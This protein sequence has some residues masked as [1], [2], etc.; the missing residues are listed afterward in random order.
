MAL[1]K[2]NS[3]SY[4]SLDATKLTGNLPAISGANLTGI[5]AANHVQIFHSES[6]TA[7]TDVTLDSIFSST[8]DFYHIKALFV[9]AN[10]DVDFLFRARIGTG[11][12]TTYSGSEYQWVWRGR[13]VGNAGGGNNDN[14]GFSD[15]SW[16]LA[17]NVRSDFDSAYVAFT[18]D[19]FDPNTNITS[20]PH[21]NADVNWHN[22]S[23]QTFYR[24]YASGKLKT[25][26]DITGLTFYFSS[27]NISEAKIVCYGVKTT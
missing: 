19:W 22:A 4:S 14:S 20:R 3:N 15:T 18:M 17:D 16:K 21:Y 24:N 8:Y 26:N 9:P 6:Q 5:V 23:N 13:Y 10:N 25:N 11:S 1:T 27:G 12:I 2:I 7:A